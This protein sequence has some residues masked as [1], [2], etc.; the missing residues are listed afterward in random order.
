MVFCVRNRLK[1]D[2]NFQF[3]VRDRSNSFRVPVPRVMVLWPG[4]AFEFEVPIEPVRSCTI[5]ETVILWML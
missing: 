3:I 1:R 5:E 4:D 2:T